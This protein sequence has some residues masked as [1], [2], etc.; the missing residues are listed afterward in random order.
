MSASV[1][2]YDGADDVGS[3]KQLDWIAAAIKLKL[4]LVRSL[5]LIHVEVDT[6][7]ES[8]ATPCHLDCIAYHIDKAVREIQ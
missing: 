8:D 7:G 4:G 3:A 1:Y 5:I 6:A 2:L